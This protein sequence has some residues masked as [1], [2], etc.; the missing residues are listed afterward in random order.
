MPSS[1]LK[2]RLEDKIKENPQSLLFAR[3]ADI[4]LDQDQVD[5]AIQLCRQGLKANPT[6]ITGHY[7]LAK[8]YLKNNEH[9]KAESALKKVL[10]HD[11]QFI[12]AHKHL[13]D[14]MIKLGWENTAVTH[15]RDI[16]K[17]DPFE[18][19]IQAH[20]ADLS[21][22][23]SE[24]V[25]LP[26]AELHDESAFS[27]EALPES[28][29]E[30]DEEWVSQIREV[31]P[32]EL[33]EETPAPSPEEPEPD[34]SD[35]E[36]G[37]PAASS[38]NS[39]EL[40]DIEA[41][42]SFTETDREKAI[43]ETPETQ[44]GAESNADDNSDFQEFD[45]DKAASLSE[46]TE[47]ESGNSGE[48]EE[49]QE[50]SDIPEAREVDQKREETPEPDQENRPDEAY[51]VLDISGIPAEQDIPEPSGM[52][53]EAFILPDFGDDRSAAGD[54]SESLS[55][56]TESGMLPATSE[57]P[58]ESTGKPDDEP[59]TLSG[60]TDFSS[61][62]FRNAEE[63]DSAPDSSFSEFEFDAEESEPHMAEE[64][65]ETESDHTS[66]DESSLEKNV[67]E[68]EDLLDLPEDFSI[69][70]FTEESL[71]LE[72]ELTEESE[73]SES[74]ARG[75]EEIQQPE[76]NDPAET[77]V[78][79]ETAAAQDSTETETSHAPSET[80]QDEADAEVTGP[81]SRPDQENADEPEPAVKN[82][83]P[84]EDETDQE[85]EI[86]TIELPEIKPAPAAPAITDSSGETAGTE[87]VKNQEPPEPKPRI[88]TPTLGEIYIAQE[89][90]DKAL[91]IFQELLEQNPDNQAYKDKIALIKEKMRDHNL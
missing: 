14:L 57:T 83:P 71:N 42:D 8:A 4:Y 6:Y 19:A 44:A 45:I 90:F 59:E 58:E 31:F 2:S 89:Q 87:S 76:I 82:E 35:A 39:G 26:S 91:S 1:D 36:S 74:E 51:E 68:P 67:P 41:D 13:G 29:K 85:P 81:V 12:S 69:E 21:E 25:E 32:E 65:S 15:Y 17:I 16:L 84:P 79:Q 27:T 77:P 9:E 7:V 23:I 46:D 64:G 24:A 80:A 88:L 40:F 11:R 20:L 54:E 55:E 50:F 86:E 78:E 18:T 63:P 61:E 56:S 34:V 75:F 37:E 28:R 62:S 43:P 52:I 47:E 22:E 73:A 49:F 66:S 5:A 48:T 53:D 33:S 72:I 70:E 60:F 3:L 30:P 38:Q 10:S